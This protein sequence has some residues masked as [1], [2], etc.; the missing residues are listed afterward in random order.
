MTATPA[1]TPESPVYS[2]M[3]VDL[4][5]VDDAFHFEAKGVAGVTLDIDGSTDIGG[6]NAG[7]RPME[8]L[9]MGLAGCSAIDVI[10]ILNKQKQI[11]DDFAI[12]V[13]GQR[14]QGATPAPFKSIHIEYR[15]QGDLDEAKV[16][17]AIDLSMD[18]YCSATAQL[19]PTADITWSLLLNQAA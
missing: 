9:L 11:I 16:R 7:A 19:R 12:R 13:Q 18:K 1:T 10:V 8:M 14:E 15:L 3:T 17:R 5:R 4:Q 6:H 2:T